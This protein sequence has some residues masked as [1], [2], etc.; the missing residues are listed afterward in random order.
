[1]KK[2]LC[3]MILLA[4]FASGFLPAQADQNAFEKAKLLIF[5][6]QWTAALK[7]AG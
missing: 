5:D 2:K 6:K 4:W 7:E 3:S 1:M